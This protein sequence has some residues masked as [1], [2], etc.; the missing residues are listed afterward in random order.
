MGCR[1]KSDKRSEEIGD[2]NNLTYLKRPHDLRTFI[3]DTVRKEGGKFCKEALSNFKGAK[4]SD[5]TLPMDTH[6]AK[7]YYEAK[8]KAERNLKES[9]E[10][11]M[12]QDLK[13]IENHVH[14]MHIR[15]REKVDKDFTS[16][17]IVKRQ[18]ILRSLSRAFVEYPSN[19]DLKVLLE[20]SMKRVRASYAYIYD[21]QKSK[22]A[23]T[24]FPWDVATRELC[25]MHHHPILLTLP[26]TSLL[27]SQR[28]KLRL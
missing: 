25:C 2:E 27:L 10:A 14:D 1:W 9:N 13:L 12:L 20:D 7:P 8:E 5:R 28:S 16:L 24:R 18:D 22:K 23:G 21:F 6:L 17:P 26:D 19:K 15:H 4:L 3:M 11:S